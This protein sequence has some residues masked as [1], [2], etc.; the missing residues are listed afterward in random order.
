MKFADWASGYR[1]TSKPRCWLSFTKP[2]RTI[3]DLFSHRNLGELA[4]SGNDAL[5]IKALGHSQ[6]N[7]MVF[8][9]GALLQDSDGAMRILG[10][11]GEQLHEVRFAEMERT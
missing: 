10:C 1:R 5:E 2:E 8:R 6:K 4:D 7:G 9:L 3:P 11:C